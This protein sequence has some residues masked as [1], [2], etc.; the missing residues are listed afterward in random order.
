MVSPRAQLSSPFLSDPLYAEPELGAEGEAFGPLL[1]SPPR[2]PF[3]SAYEADDGPGVGGVQA[4]AFLA[5]LYDHEFDDAVQELVNDAT[6][7]YEVRRFEM[8]GYGEGQSR[9]AERVLE[10]HFAP[11]YREAQ[12]MIDSV[13]GSV[14]DRAE[15]SLSE[16][17]LDAL[18]D[19]YA[20]PALEPAFELFFGKLKKKLKKVAK[21]GLNL[22][23]KGVKA[24]SHRALALILDKLR[25]LVPKLVD[26]VL[27]AAIGKLPPT[28]R[29]HAE[30]LRD[31][32]LQK[33]GMREAPEEDDANADTAEIQ[34]EF[35][36]SVT[37]ILFGSETADEALFA[38]E[39]ARGMRA[40]EKDVVDQLNL[41]RARFAERVTALRAGED[42]TPLV[43]EF[44]PAILPALKLGIKLAG[45]NRVVS[46]LAGQV[47]RLI[48]RFVGQQHTPALSQALV[49]AGLRMIHLEATPEDGLTAAGEAVAGTVEETV[50]RVAAAPDY[51][52]A[53]ERLLEGFVLEAFHDSAAGLLPSMLPERVYETRPELRS[54]TLGG[55]WIFQPL[56][57][58]TRRYQEYTRVPEVVITPQ[59]ASGVR[60]FGDVPLGDYLQQRFGMPA[61]RTVRARMHL[62]RAIPGTSLAGISAIERNLR[63]LGRESGYA[64]GDF[65][66][67]TPEAAGFLLREPGL[68]VAVGPQYLAGRTRCAVGQRFYRLEVEGAPPPL[69]AIHAARAAALRSTELNVAFDFPASRIIVSLFLS[70]RDAQRVAS[71]LRDPGRATAVAGSLRTPF[72]ERLIRCLTGAA[73]GHTCIVLEGGHLLHGGGAAVLRLPPRMQMQAA[74]RIAD[75]IGLRLAEQLGE[76]ADSVIS[77]TEADAD[78]ITLT[79]TLEAPPGMTE[80]RAALAGGTIDA[81]AELPAMPEPEGRVEVVPGFTRA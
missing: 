49:D 19:G 57:G 18:F 5:E 29:P 34:R 72:R 37:E 28:L 33:V 67:L 22:A 51:V 2:S 24:V 23:K 11:L 40:N 17:E 58:T 73:P 64:L 12:A 21:K 36:E 10:T 31:T 62:Y 61:G 52:L 16:A 9:G 66:P 35:D 63:G 44:V 79:V 54:S 38:A 60:S 78:G 8:E 48:G 45:R 32:F 80:L 59:L 20:P 39:V 26:R 7:L 42:A 1:L 15:D 50:R 76:L 43:E 6:V 53:D 47:A 81:G 71:A 25:G 65:H 41:A 68:G 55:A 3:V 13:R 77:A 4:S 27:E 56:R 46:F 74:T 69:V 14:A 30:K 70:E 75:W